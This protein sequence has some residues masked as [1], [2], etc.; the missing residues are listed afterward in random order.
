MTE[1][2]AELG[3]TDRADFHALAACDTLHH[4]D[5]GTVCGSGHVRSIEQLRCTDGVAGTGRAVADADDLV[6]AVQVG[7]LMDETFLLGD[8]ENLHDFLIGAVTGVLMAF[9]QEFR[10]VTDRQDFIHDHDLRIQMGGH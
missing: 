5:M 2:L 3:S 7:D 4:V 10:H 9:H 1:L 6:F 8:F